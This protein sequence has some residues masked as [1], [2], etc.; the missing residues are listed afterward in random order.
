MMCGVDGA[1]RVNF[2]RFC[3]QGEEHVEEVLCVG[4]VGPGVHDGLAQMRLVSDGS[5]GGHL[6]NLKTFISKGR[7]PHAQLSAVWTDSYQSGAGQLSLRGGRYVQSVVEKGRESAHHSNH[8]SHGVR[9]ALEASEE[10]DELLVHHSLLLDIPLKS[11]L[12][13]TRRKLTKHQ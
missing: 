12:L 13:L 8:N 1:H 11:F 4:E 9:V 5:D 7:Y 2:I 6:G 10:G 3:G